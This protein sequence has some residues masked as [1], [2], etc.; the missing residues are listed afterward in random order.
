MRFNDLKSLG[1]NSDIDNLPFDL[2][3]KLIEL[4]Y[5][6]NDRLDDELNFIKDYFEFENNKNNFF[7][8]NK[9]KRAFTNKVNDY[10][11]IN[12]LDDYEIELI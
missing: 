3:Y 11:K 2:L 9:I 4:V 1:I 6:N 7:D 12:N 8:K 10:K 5:K